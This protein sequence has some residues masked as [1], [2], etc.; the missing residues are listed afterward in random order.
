LQVAAVVENLVAAAV[1]VDLQYLH[2]S[3]F[4]VLRQ[5]QSEQVAQVNT[6]PMVLMA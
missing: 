6:T 4:Q 5:S 1:L 2:L 3:R